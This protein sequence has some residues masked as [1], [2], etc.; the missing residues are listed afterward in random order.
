M[1]LLWLSDSAVACDSDRLSP[2]A[3]KRWVLSDVSFEWHSVYLLKPDSRQICGCYY[4]QLSYHALPLFSPDGATGHWMSFHLIRS[5]DIVYCWRMKRTIEH[6]PPNV[7][8]ITL[9]HVGRIYIA[10]YFTIE[11]Q[12][13]TRKLLLCIFLVTYDYVF[14]YLGYILC[15]FLVTMCVTA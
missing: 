13:E 15:R 11:L 4:W 9:L 2:L 12:R 3:L 10:D 8:S 14:T 6:R 5:Y 7:F 1:L